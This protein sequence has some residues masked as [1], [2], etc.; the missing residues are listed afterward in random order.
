MVYRGRIDDLY[1]DFA[2]G[3]YAA[4]RYDLRDVLE[5]VT[6]DKAIAPRTTR[7]V[8]CPIAD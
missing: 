7:A 6:H 8:G 2:R 5:A 1:A 3:R 4:T